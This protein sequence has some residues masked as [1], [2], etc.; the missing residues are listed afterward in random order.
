VAK[1]A[2]VILC[3]LTIV[4]TSAYSQEKSHGTAEENDR[5]TLYGP[6]K[7]QRNILNIHAT[8]AIPFF[9]FCLCPALGIDDRC[10][11][12]LLDAIGLCVLDAPNALPV[13]QEAS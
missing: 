2:V 4:C 13:E 5:L 7:C 1:N 6:C 3:K 9:Y 10:H 12:Q 8:T 11:N